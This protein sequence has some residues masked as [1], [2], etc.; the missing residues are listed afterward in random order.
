MTHQPISATSRKSSTMK[1]GR[2]LACQVQGLR[3]LDLCKRLDGHWQRLPEA[4]VLVFRRRRVR[5]W[6]VV[7]LWLVFEAI[8]QAECLCR[9]VLSMKLCR[10]SRWQRTLRHRGLRKLALNSRQP[11]GARKMAYKVRKTPIIAA[12]TTTAESRVS[13]SGCELE[14]PLTP[15]MN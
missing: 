14:C 2:R 13:F 6:F 8:L 9:Q 3:T 11:G 5:L 4:R 15:A 12:K 10:S 1:N 7:L